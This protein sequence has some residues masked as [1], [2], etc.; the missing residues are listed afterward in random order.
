MSLV[1][2]ATHL[3]RLA[4]IAQVSICCT[5]M[6]D[7][8]LSIMFLQSGP[9]NYYY[10]CM[11]PPNPSHYVRAL[12]FLSPHTYVPGSSQNPH[13]GSNKNRKGFHRR[14]CTILVCSPAIAGLDTH[15]NIYIYIYILYIYQVLHI[16]I[17]T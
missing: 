9:D 14:A 8:F 10:T 12:F 4:V 7:D 5:I 2:P 17:C 11:F 3:H 13:H 16:H 1:V 6:H 15:H